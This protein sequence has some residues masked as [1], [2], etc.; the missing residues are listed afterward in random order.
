MSKRMMSDLSEEERG[1]LG[2]GIFDFL[3]G[4]T[5][6]DCWFYCVFVERGDFGVGNKTTRLASRSDLPMLEI[7]R[8]HIDAMIAKAKREA[9][10]E[11]PSL[12]KSNPF[13]PRD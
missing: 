1:R 12:L 6:S 2:N 11:E 13:I 5:P 7:L 3:K 4:A 8:G 9:P 10:K